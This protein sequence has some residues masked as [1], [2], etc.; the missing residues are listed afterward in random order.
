M[1]FDSVP[2]HQL[3]STLFQIPLTDVY[4]DPRLELR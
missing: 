4:L 2:G 3:H 1:L